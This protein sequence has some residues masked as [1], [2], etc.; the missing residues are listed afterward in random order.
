MSLTRSGTRNSPR[1]TPRCSTVY[2]ESLLG[3]STIQ[4]TKAAHE[5]IVQ[6]M[7]TPVHRQ[8]LIKLADSSDLGWR[9]VQEYEA[10]ILAD[11]SEEALPSTPTAT[12]G[13]RRADPAGS[14]LTQLLVTWR[15]RQLLWQEQELPVVSRIWEKTR[16]LLQMRKSRSLAI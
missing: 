10:H 3:D 15:R 13:R 6:G 14:I 8:K 7:N 5:K 4:S 9:I 12:L 2:T 16:A 1:S 11:N